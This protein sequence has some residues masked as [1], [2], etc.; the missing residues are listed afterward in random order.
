MNCV[1]SRRGGVRLNPPPSRLRVTTFSSRLL[2]LSSFLFY[3]YISF[4]LPAGSPLIYDSA[5]YLVCAEGRKLTDVHPILT[6]MFKSILR[7]FGAEILKIF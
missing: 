2:G 4:F 7:T 1:E 6:I 5:G 3:C